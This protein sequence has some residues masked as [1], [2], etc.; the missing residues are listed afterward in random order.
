MSLRDAYRQKMEAQL[1][2][3]RAR[4]ELLKARAKRAVADGKIMAYE[5]LADAE[6]KLASAKARL[7]HL[8]TSSEGAFDELKS[9]VESAWKDLTEACRKAAGKFGGKE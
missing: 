6:Q 9:G 2:E 4:L 7:K 8:A 1:E 3:Q 5:E